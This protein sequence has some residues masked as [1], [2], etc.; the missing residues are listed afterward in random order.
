MDQWSG[1]VAIVTG[2]ASGIGRALCKEMG[3]RG[4]VVVAADIDADGGQQTA[5]AVTSAG[6]RAS[7][8]EV[9]VAQAEAVEELVGWTYSRFG[10]LDYMFNNAGVTVGGD[11]RDMG[12]GHWRYALDVN[13]WGVVYGTVAAYRVM[14]KQGFGHIVNTAS[15]GGLVP[16]PM[17]TAYAVAKHGVVGLSTSLRA[18]AADLGVRVSV[19]CPGFIRTGVSDRALNVTKVK[20]EEALAHALAPARMMSAKDCARLILR[21]VEKNRAIITVTAPARLIW[22]L[23]RLWPSLVVGLFRKMARDYRAL[24]VEP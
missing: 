15:V 23:Y 20:D 12:L 1:K 2:G 24:R 3:R 7:A 8:V 18:E 14:V 9:D 13:L 17:G 5:A 10:R 6:G 11:L 4:A 22:W 21:G 19:V 16:V